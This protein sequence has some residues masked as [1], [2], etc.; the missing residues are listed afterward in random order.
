[1]RQGNA[2]DVPRAKASMIAVAE[3]F[4]A[5]R[6]D[7]QDQN[8]TVTGAFGDRGLLRPVPTFGSIVVGTHV[9]Q[10]LSEAGTL[11]GSAGAY[12]MIVPIATL[13]VPASVHAVLAARIDRLAE[14]EQQTLQTPR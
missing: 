14:R 7:P 1:M 13:D 6:S 5:C 9:V 3:Q 2:R 10:S 4:A 12:R 8:D 11:Q